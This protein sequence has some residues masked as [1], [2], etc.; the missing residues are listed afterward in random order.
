MLGVVVAATG[1]TVL[2]GTARASQL[3]VVG[4]VDANARSAYDILIRPAGSRAEAEQSRGLVRGDF[5][6][7]IFGGITLDQYSKVK[8]LPGVQIAAPVEMVGYVQPDADQWVDVT[9]LMSPTG[10][11]L[12]RTST[13]WA[14][15]R[16]TT[17]IT[18]SPQYAY[19]SPYQLEQE[20][21]PN[22]SVFDA[23]SR[24]E[25]KTTVC[26]QAAHLTPFEEPALFWCW[27]RQQKY[28]QDFPVPLG[29][30][31]AFHQYVDV[32]WHAP[33]LIAAVDPVAEAQLA[34]LDKAV[35]SGRYL[36]ASDVAAAADPDPSG[37]TT[38]VPVLAA[39]TSQ[40]DLS[41]V[42]RAVAMPAS[43]ADAVADGAGL[44]A[45]NKVPVDP[46][47]GR[48]VATETSQNAYARFL[49]QLL[50]RNTTN[51]TQ[52]TGF[53][54]YW[55]GSSVGY[56]DSPAGLV[57]QAVTNPLS[58]WHSKY[59][60][61]YLYPAAPTQD[62]NY[63]T[64]GPHPGTV[65]AVRI[66][67]RGVGTFDPAKLPEFSAL[68]R[69]PL[70]TYQSA[71]V[72]P[73]DAA[74]SAA[75]RGRDLL[76]DGSLTGY[77]QTT[78]TLLTTL[79]AAQALQGSAFTDPASV[80]P[81]SSIRVRVTGVT[82]IDPVSR[83][84]IRTVA[85]AIQAATGL[86]VDVTVGS[87]PSPQTIALPAG[88]FGRPALRLS[89]NWVKKG[90]AT[91]IVNAVNRKS[92]V[93]FILV[94]VV[95][96]LFVG[97]AAFASV[98]TRV[99]ELGVL[100]CLGWRPRRLFGLVAAELLLLGAVAGTTATLLSVP[101]GSLVGAPVSWGRAALAIPASVLL[102]LVA[103]LVPAAAAARAVPMEAVRSTARPPRRASRVTRV[104]GLAWATVRRRP[105]RAVLAGLGLVVAVAAFTLLL[106][107]TLAFRGT[108]VG[109]LLGGAVAVQVRGADYAAT[110]ATLFLAGL[111]V[112]DVLYISLHERAAEFATL[113]AVG[114]RESALARLLV[115]E[116]TVIGAAGALVGAGLGLAGVAAFATLTPAVF[117]GAALAAATGVLIAVVA[118][119]VTVAALGG[120]PTVELLSAAE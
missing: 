60:Q 40:D 54:V 37:E 41:S 35:V 95:C 63:R 23:E 86:D 21:G 3:Q 26:P 62:T 9:D 22:G 117:L 69:V 98:R 52:N 34:G 65:P 45:L 5:L 61:A 113:R 111:G 48:V 109:S 90:V 92:L 71:A 10:R 25:G 27:S 56:R 38:V 44:P 114:W 12:V 73:A 87:S 85:S 91:S 74:A 39:S 94:L 24:P 42:T 30:T 13:T 31:K 16:G 115:T 110:A 81:V 59:D 64:L 14:T 104:S 49:Q 28:Y 103:G 105:G 1:F 20:L 78:P 70:G 66:Q 75:L 108:L 118:S 36:H 72:R 18:N 29:D 33:A 83:E 32:N 55:T 102:A 47:A 77:L 80:A 101:L 19:L 96:A 89:E 97:N 7:G 6:S 43:A 2:T 99:T 15:D 8:A 58:V 88:R 112:A 17:H 50:N 68:S 84:R 76:P 120:L 51:A 119:T 67:L 107:V 100:A 11:S 79:D 4:T 57:P 53:T 82:G 93:L 116:G 46:T 106:A